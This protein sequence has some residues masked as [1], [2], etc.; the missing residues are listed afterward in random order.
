MAAIQLAREAG[1]R[2]Q[3]TA[4]T[5]VKLGFCRGLGTAL[6]LRAA[7]AR[8]RRLARRGGPDVP[9][10]RRAGCARVPEGLVSAYLFGSLAEGRSHRE[11]DVDIGILLDRTKLPEKSGR[12]E[13]R[14]RLGSQL[15]VALGRNDLDIVALNDAPPS[16]AARI[17]TRGR[18]G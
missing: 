2:V 7:A 9:A 6:G 13:V 15:A 12:F 8:E 10:W 5:E 18:S 11:S 16:L 4:G 1:A 3:A 17:V 14:I